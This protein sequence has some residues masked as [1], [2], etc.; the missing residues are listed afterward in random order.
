MGSIGTL[1]PPLNLT[2]SSMPF[3]VNHSIKYQIINQASS[4]HRSILQ[5]KLMI[6]SSILEWSRDQGLTNQMC[7]FF[8]LFVHGN[9]GMDI[10]RSTLFLI[11]TNLDIIWSLWP[12]IQAMTK[13]SRE[14]QHVDMTISIFSN[15]MTTSSWTFSQWEAQLSFA[16]YYFPKIKLIPL[17]QIGKS[18]QIIVLTVHCGNQAKR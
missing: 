3:N 10:F 5:L 13:G 8:M 9:L 2:V 17:P 15:W 6:L 12:G 16:P 4:C 1:F 7:C 18:L 14:K 11:L